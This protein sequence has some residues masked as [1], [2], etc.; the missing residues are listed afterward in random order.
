MCKLGF[1]PLLC[2]LEHKSIRKCN[3]IINTFHDFQLQIRRTKYSVTSKGQNYIDLGKSTKVI[4]KPN[5]KHQS[6]GV[7]IYGRYQK[8]KKS[9][10]RM[11]KLY[12]PCPPP[13]F[14]YSDKLNYKNI[15]VF[16]YG[17][18]EILILELM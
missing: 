16:L 14:N 7:K 10:C 18:G 13:N 3:N 17:W 9:L 5:I 6:I 11:V 8:Q 15:Y 1:L 12:S 4:N 2:I